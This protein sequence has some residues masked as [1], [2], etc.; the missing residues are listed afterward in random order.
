MYERT[1]FNLLTI[2]R[3]DAVHNDWEDIAVGPCYAI[4]D[5]W[6]CIF[7]LDD[8]TVNGTTARTIYKLFEP[9][10]LVDQKMIIEDTL[11]FE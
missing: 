4:G 9:T 7:I 11:V 3:R 10:E 5:H 6:S 1:T 8:G 2:S